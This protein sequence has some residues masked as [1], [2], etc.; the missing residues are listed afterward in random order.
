M[1]EGT[2]G[3]VDIAVIVE[4]GGRI[5]TGYPTGGRGVQ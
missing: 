5:K 2:V 4:P 1:Y 3:D